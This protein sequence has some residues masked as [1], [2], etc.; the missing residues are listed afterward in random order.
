MYTVILIGILGFAG[1]LSVRGM[2]NNNKSRWITGVLLGGIT[3]LF[4]WFMG[5]WGEYLWFDS[6]GYRPRFIK[7]FFTKIGLAFAAGFIAWL[8]MHL[9]SLFIPREQKKL[10][11]WQ[12]AGGTLIGF[13][14]GLAHWDRLLIYINRIPG[15][16]SDPIL[17]QDTGFY[18]FVLP[19]LDNLYTYFILLFLFAFIYLFWSGFLKTKNNEL[20]IREPEPENQSRL[21]Q[22]LYIT[23]GLLLLV[24]AF[25]YYLQRFH[26]MYSSLGAVQGPGWTD[27]HIRL[28]VYHIMILMMLVLTVFLLIPGLRRLWIRWI[29]RNQSIRFEPV[30]VIGTM[31]GFIF[32]VW[33]ITLAVLPGLLQWL[34]V[35]PNE[36]SL[37]KPYI[38]H[39]IDWTRKGFALDRVEEKEF[40]AEAGLTQSLIRQ[41]QKV[42]NNIRLWDYR[43]LDAV[44]KQFQEIRLYYEFSDVDI[45]RYHMNGDYRQVMI[46]AREM[47]QQNLPAQ[48]RT[49]VNKRFKYTHGYGLTLTPVNEFTRK[50]LPNLL[51]KDIP[52]KSVNTNLKVDVP[53]I[54]YG[55][56]TRSHVVANSRE[57]EFDYPRAV[58]PTG[59]PRMRVRVAYRC[60]IS[61][62]S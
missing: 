52:P 38:A 43:A 10:R 29:L 37:E 4:Y 1:Y 35:Q 55:E 6:I 17:H 22:G 18:L 50:G 40:P 23:G 41:N 26:L 9:F 24:F 53:E 11:F 19:F 7:V 34:R 16:A 56:L 51:I 59:I 62:A 8:L 14:W 44:Y 48:S 60:Q 32:A 49:F 13:F 39:N 25:H 54:Y 58:K 31:A 15:G 45:D 27:V 20:K 30:Y 36:I 28:P 3:L 33:L 21:Y 42:F 47:N 12:R 61:G 46:S 5:F 2:Q 57:K